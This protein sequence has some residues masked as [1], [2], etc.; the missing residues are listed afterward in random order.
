MNVVKNVGCV[1]VLGLAGIYG[2]MIYATDSVWKIDVQFSFIYNEGWLLCSQLHIRYQGYSGRLRL[3]SGPGNTK[4]CLAQ[5]LVGMFST[6][7][8]NIDEH[9]PP[10]GLTQFTITSMG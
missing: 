3:C 10:S 6:V 1:R 7:Q 5:N 9:A 2:I 8:H 4:E